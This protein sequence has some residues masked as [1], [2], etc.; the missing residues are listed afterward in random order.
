MAEGLDDDRKTGEDDGQDIGSVAEEA[1]KLFGALSGWA[2]EHGSEEHIATGAPECTYC[3]VC[4]CGVRS[5]ARPSRW[6]WRR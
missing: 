5:T 3:P 1:A 2:R 6:A 4:R